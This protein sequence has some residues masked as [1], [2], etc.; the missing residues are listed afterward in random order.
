MVG[1][2]PKTAVKW[3]KEWGSLDGVIENAGRITP[4]WC[5]SVIYE[6][7]ELLQRNKELIKL[8][9]KFNETDFKPGSPQINA[10]EKILSEMEMLKSLEE[11]KRRYQK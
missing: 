3:L 11:V 2:G 6:K 9:D 5:G 1:V 4:K 8:D 7:R 10:M